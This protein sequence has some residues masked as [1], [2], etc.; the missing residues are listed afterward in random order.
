M[1]TLH[2]R[3]VI[4]SVGFGKEKMFIELSTS[5]ILSVPYTYTPKLQ[6]AN[7]QELQEYRLI[8][9]GI[10]IHFTQIDEDLSLEGLIRDFGNESKRINISIQ[11]N[12]LD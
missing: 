11:A 3:A 4:T 5:K 7:Y 1:S 9:N 12:L 8:G 2:N 6:N 10:G